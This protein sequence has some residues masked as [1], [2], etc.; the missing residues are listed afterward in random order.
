[1]AACTFTGA[2]HWFHELALGLTASVYSLEV[3]G[4]ILGKRAPT[5]VTPAFTLKRSS[6]ARGLLNS[7]C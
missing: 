5:G 4:S 3:P 1:M 6:E 2:L 7:G